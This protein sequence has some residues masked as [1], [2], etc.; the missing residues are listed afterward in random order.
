M[1]LHKCTHIFPC[2]ALFAAPQSCWPAL[3]GS[4]YIGHMFWQRMSHMQRSRCSRLCAFKVLALL[5]SALLSLSITQNICENTSSCLQ[6]L[7]NL[8]KAKRASAKW[9][10]P[11][12]THTHTHKYYTAHTQI[13][14]AR[15]HTTHALA[16][17]WGLVQ[18]QTCAILCLRH[19]ECVPHRHTHTQ[20]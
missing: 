5:A 6:S 4:G 7:A 19:T 10:C 14:T 20:T 9:L 13:C 16:K 18:I 8:S 11:P 12:P 15:A 2:I 3:K 1:H 17:F